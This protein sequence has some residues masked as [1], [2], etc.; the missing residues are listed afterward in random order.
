[1]RRRC[2]IASFAHDVFLLYISTIFLAKNYETRPMQFSVKHYRSGSLVSSDMKHDVSV[3]V[4]V[5]AKA[6][7]SRHQREQEG[8]EP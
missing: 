8:G 5:N 3:S 2:G 6:I 1:M 4:L 7:Q